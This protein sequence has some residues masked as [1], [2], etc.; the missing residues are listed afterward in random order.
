MREQ[1]ISS[2][3]RMTEWL[4]AR[5]ERMI[6]RRA[7]QAEA[8]GAVAGSA[9]R[10]AESV[11]GRDEQLCPSCIFIYDDQGEV[12]EVIDCQTNQHHVLK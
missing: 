11:L 6:A 4:D 8:A 5:T 12:T 9:A 7:Q 1:L 10:G 3:N 2:L